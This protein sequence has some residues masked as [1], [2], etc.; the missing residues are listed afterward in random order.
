MKTDLP[1][2]EGREVQSAVAKFSGR[3]SSR[4]GA[5]GQDEFVIVVARVKVNKVSHQDFKASSGANSPKLYTRVH[6]CTTTRA[7]VLPEEQGAKI[8]E[9]AQMWSDDQF[10]IQGLFNG[11]EKSGDEG[12]DESAGE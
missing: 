11:I 1:S 3:T 2:F 9:E 12:D 4:V 6:E 8:L 7:I 10:G 5:L